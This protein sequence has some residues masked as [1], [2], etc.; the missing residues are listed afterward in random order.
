MNTLESQFEHHKL[1]RM[2]Y[3]CKNRLWCSGSD[4]GHLLEHGNLPFAQRMPAYQSNGYMINSFLMT[5]PLYIGWSTEKY[6]IFIEIPIGYET[7]LATLF[8]ILRL[9]ILPSDPRIIV[10]SL[11][12]DFLYEGKFLPR[13]ECDNLWRH[14]AQAFKQIGWTGIRAFGGPTY[15]DYNPRWAQVNARYI[16]IIPR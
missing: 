8:R 9:F 16:E 2:K 11:A 1:E 14:Y 4:F 12:H 13:L 3:M 6:Y 5:E 10:A 7:D 15:N